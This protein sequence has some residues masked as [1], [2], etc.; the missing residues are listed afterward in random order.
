MAVNNVETLVMQ[1][2]D[3]FVEYWLRRMYIK[4]ADWECMVSLV[5]ICWYILL[6][7]PWVSEQPH[8]MWCKEIDF[9]AKLA[10]ILD[11]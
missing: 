5:F 4:I 10:T 8:I 1:V 11:A 2:K 6:I 9:V 3:V 7:P